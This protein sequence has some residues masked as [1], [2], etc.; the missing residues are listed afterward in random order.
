MGDEARMK[1]RPGQN[2][3]TEGKICSL[4]TRVGGDTELLRHSPLRNGAPPG[5]VAFARRGRGGR[6]TATPMPI[7]GLSGT[8]QAYEVDVLANQ[9]V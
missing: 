8:Q 1:V 6:Q 3:S 2:A 9:P 7:M 5:G 4:G